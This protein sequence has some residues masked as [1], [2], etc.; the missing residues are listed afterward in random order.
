MNVE[1]SVE[2]SHSATS[3]FKHATPLFELEYEFVH[4][5]LCGAATFPS[6][7]D[8][9]ELHFPHYEALGECVLPLVEAMESWKVWEK[10]HYVYL[11]TSTF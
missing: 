9:G 4:G 6:H 7:V 8:G 5:P 2:S 11:P 3:Y 1:M 10:L